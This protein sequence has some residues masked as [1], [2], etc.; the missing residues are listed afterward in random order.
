MILLAHS[1]G[2]IVARWYLEKLG[3]HDREA[4]GYAVTITPAQ[5][6]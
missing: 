1:M 5:A 6:A 4:L 3:G 2:G